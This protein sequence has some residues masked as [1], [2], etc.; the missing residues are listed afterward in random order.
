MF[1]RPITITTGVKLQIQDLTDGVDSEG[2]ADWGN[3]SQVFC[4]LLRRFA[5]IDSMTHISNEIWETF[6]NYYVPHQTN[7][8]SF[9]V[10]SCGICLHWSVAQS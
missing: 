6:Q 4:C 3:L 2:S 10:A 9:G 8:Q 5:Y 1:T 7:L